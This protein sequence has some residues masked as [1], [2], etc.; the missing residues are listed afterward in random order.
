M[1]SENHIWRFIG[2]PT[3]LKN[4]FSILLVGIASGVLGVGLGS[5]M[6]DITTKVVINH[7]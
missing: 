4:E 3:Q 2:S 1:D 5:I 7:E 6:I